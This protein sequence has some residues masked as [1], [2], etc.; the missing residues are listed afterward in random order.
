MP[1]EQRPATALERAI[2]SQPEELA[3]IAAQTPVHAAV[4]RLHRAHRI[5]LVGTGTSQHAAELGAAMLNEAGRAAQ[6]VS[7]MHFVTW[8]PHVA[9]QDVAPDKKRSHP[10]NTIGTQ[11]TASSSRETP[12]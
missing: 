2:R 9:Q 7:S 3:R 10:P 4:E 8:A 6:A 1:K 5:W 12:T 11:G